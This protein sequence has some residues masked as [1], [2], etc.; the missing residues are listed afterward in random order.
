MKIIYFD[1]V[2]QAI[3]FSLSEIQRYQSSKSNICLTGG[4]FGIDFCSKLINSKLDISDWRIFQTDERLGTDKEETIQLKII[5]S[6][7]VCKGYKDSNM[8]FFP[9][10]KIELESGLNNLSMLNI[11]EKFDLVFLSLGED[12]HLAGH[13]KNSEIFKGGIFCTTNNAPK[14]P[15]E[16]ISY[17]INYLYKSKK[18]I[19][20]CFGQSKEIALKDFIS[21]KGTH[22]FLKDHRNITLLTNLQDVV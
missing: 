7:K 15:K 16:R 21:G 12:G 22:S 3:I 11:E 20:V 19:L 1:R 8:T 10:S 5:E 9:R 13:F 4:R 18:I 17:T 6:L 14:K 2:E